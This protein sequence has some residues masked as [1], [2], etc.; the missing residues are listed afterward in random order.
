MAAGKEARISPAASLPLPCRSSLTR[1][2]ELPDHLTD[3]SGKDGFLGFNQ[4][5][6]GLAGDVQIDLS[7]VSAVAVSHGGLPVFEVGLHF[8]K[9]P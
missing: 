6:E 8:R 9:L 1:F 4:Q 2:P 5:D 7:V 3:I